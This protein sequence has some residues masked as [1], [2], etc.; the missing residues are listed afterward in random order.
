M[1]CSKTFYK[2]KLHLMK[3]KETKD[4]FKKLVNILQIFIFETASCFVSSIK[5]EKLN[6]FTTTQNYPCTKAN[7]LLLVKSVIKWARQTSVLVIA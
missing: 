2:K 3:S 6:N 1:E 5:K 7:K 4:Y